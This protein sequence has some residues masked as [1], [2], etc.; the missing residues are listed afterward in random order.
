MRKPAPPKSI[1][2][3]SESGLAMR[4]DIDQFLCQRY[5]EIFRDRHGDPA[6]TAMCWGFEFGDGWFTLL[7][8]L[9]AAITR[10]VGAGTMPPVVA[11]QV[12]EQSGYLRFRISETGST[13]TAIP[14][15]IARLK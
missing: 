4:A 15:C 6:D 1:R 9:C 11:T 10:K 12:K 13:A 7:E 14:R 5:P 8:N 2:Q 3:R